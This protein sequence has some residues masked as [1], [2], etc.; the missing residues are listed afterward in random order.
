M[1]GVTKRFGPRLALAGVDWEVAAGE[2]V[3]VLGANGAGKTTLL[4]LLTL[5][6]APTTGTVQVGDSVSG[7]L[8][9]E[10]RKLLRRA[11][12][13]VFEDLRLLPDR[14]VFENLALALHVRGVWDRRRVEERVRQALEEIGLS[15][16]A[17]SL[18][19]ELSAGERQAVCVAR[20]LIGEPT[21]VLAD[22]PTR[23]LGDEMSRQILEVLRRVHARGA[24]VVITTNEDAVA[25]AF[26]GRV[27]CLHEG[28]LE[29][30]DGGPRP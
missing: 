24:T 14:P 5:E 16:R 25:H 21:L 17:T 8:S 9:R 22:E 20:A 30:M 2:R 13:V 7:R 18:P 23:H 1:T 19:D 27:W 28:R 10:Q 26:G 6:I 4:R 11:I 12:G 29:P 15:S 3:A